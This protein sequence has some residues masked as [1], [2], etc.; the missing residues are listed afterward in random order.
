MLNLGHECEV[1]RVY[2][3][4]AIG[5]G[6]DDETDV[7]DMAGFEAV[8]F[9]VVFGTIGAAGATV[10]AEQDEFDD[11]A[12]GA[13]EDLDGTE[14]AVDD[15]DSDDVVIIDVGKPEN[16]YI[17]LFMDDLGDDTTVDAVVALKYRARDLPV[18]Q[19]ATIAETV[20]V[21]TPEAV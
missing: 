21:T 10:V 6:G 2:E 4:G 7:V 3:A 19:G 20:V 1:E 5:A 11:I 18:T 13:A 9:V 17:R 8:A 12:F 16:R 14:V 15:G